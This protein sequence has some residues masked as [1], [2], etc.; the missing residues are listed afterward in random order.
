MPNGI[1]KVFATSTY[2]VPIPPLLFWIS[3]KS[4]FVARTR[5]SIF[6]KTTDLMMFFL[7]DQH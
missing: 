5:K 2:K 6:K 1:L 4:L 7:G 3:C